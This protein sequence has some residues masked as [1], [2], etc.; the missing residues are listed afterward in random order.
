[1]K[2]FYILV[3]KD[4]KIGKGKF[5]GQSSHATWTYCLR[6]NNATKDVV[7]ELAEN[8]LIEYIYLSQDML[9]SIEKT[10]SY[11]V[12]RDKGLT[13]LK[14]NSL[15]CI[16]LGYLTEK[17]KEDTLKEFSEGIFKCNVNALKQ[18]SC[19][20]S[21]NLA[22]YIIVNKNIQVEKE[23]LAK[24]IS[25]TMFK[26][27]LN[28]NYSEEYIKAYMSAQKKIV[29]KCDED[30]IHEVIEDNSIVIKDNNNKD[31]I[32][33]VNIGIKDKDLV[34]DNVKSLKL[35]NK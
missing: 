30:F 25:N 31:K 21:S 10:K 24:V 11:I 35:Y 13:Q 15:T 7:S 9:E 34:S 29:L 5:A 18:V 19:E 8:D 28:N 4:L 32:I 27:F 12:I 22:M 33:C 23:E 6:N 17:E 3:N 20:D 16:V 14:E 2:K 26:L 1:M